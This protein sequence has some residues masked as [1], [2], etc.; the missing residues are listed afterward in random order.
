MFLIYGLTIAFL[1]Y[2]PIAG[3]ITMVIFIFLI[4]FIGCS[5]DD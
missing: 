3:W 2:G 5:G 4:G 1:I